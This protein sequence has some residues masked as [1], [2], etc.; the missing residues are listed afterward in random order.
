MP[1]TA[2][3]PINE[4][5]LELPPA[6]VPQGEKD[7]PKNK[8]ASS[9]SQDYFGSPDEEIT[10]ENLPSTLCYYDMLR[11]SREK[12][13]SRGED[14]S[15]L[16]R[17]LS[18]VKEKG[19]RVVQG[20]RP[21][22]ENSVYD[23]F[24]EEASQDRSG[25]LLL[26][27]DSRGGELSQEAVRG[28]Y[29]KSVE[30]YYLPAQSPLLHPEKDNLL[31]E[32]SPEKAVVNEIVADLVREG[33]ADPKITEG[34]QNSRVDFLDDRTA[35]LQENALPFSGEEN[36][37]AQRTPAAKDPQERIAEMRGTV[38]LAQ[39]LVT[40]IYGITPV[41][42]GTVIIALVS[43]QT[44]ERFPSTMQGI[45]VINNTVIIPAEQNYDQKELIKALVVNFYAPKSGIYITPEVTEALVD[46]ALEIGPEKIEEP[47][48]LQHK[49]Q[50]EEK[51]EK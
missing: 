45:K 9:L 25:G 10:S 41:R 12:K 3:K 50:I 23:L 21:K 48:V 34:L 1:D 49:P 29:A 14:T 30:N 46:E 5:E 36:E 47:L 51:V 38:R 42:E 24:S 37:R 8:E 6:N 33:I 13:A 19:G 26:L 15:D 40:R 18:V 43:D 11:Q 27:R 28:Y 39:E 44:N 31:E 17:Q 16:D 20:L 4:F 35:V 22:K 7:L 2:K 32:T